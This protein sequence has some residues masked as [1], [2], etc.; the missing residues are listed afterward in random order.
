MSR[1]HMSRFHM[2][3]FHGMQV[4]HYRVWAPPETSVR[5]EY[6][7]EV[8]REAARHERGVLYGTR[9]GATLRVIAARREQPERDS[10]ISNLDLLG[11][12]AC[13]ERGEIFLT[14]PDLQHLELTGGSIALVV[15]GTNAG[16]FVYEP[17]GAI[18]TI[19]SYREFS[20]VD[21]PAAAPVPS[22]DNKVDRPDRR[23]LWIS[24]ACLIP[25]A[26]SVAHVPRARPIALSV[27]E[28]AHQ[29]RITWNP[30]AFTNARLEIADGLERNWIPVP[31]RLASATYVP[32]SSDVRIRLIAGSR[33]ENAHFVGVDVTPEVE[34]V[35][36]LESEAE[37]LRAR[38]TRG[39]ERTSRL[40]TAIQRTLAKLQ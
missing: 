13:R 40:Q 24:L 39:A 10:R 33:S 38:L 14:E 12:F 23:K 34:H 3:R 27:H 19:Q 30:A 17:D 25:L 20:L 5:V 8:L 7:E 4:P 37:S 6:S 11:T 35:K 28:D 22:G 31:P 9:D 18:Q 32:H 2:S 16:F 29:L 26:V 36:Q 15:A 21:R 1:F